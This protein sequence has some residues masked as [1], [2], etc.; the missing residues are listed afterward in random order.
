MI[1]SLLKIILNMFLNLN[2][3]K[4]SYTNNGLFKKKKVNK[5][6]KIKL[7]INNKLKQKKHIINFRY[8]LK[9]F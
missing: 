8:K 3:N 5:K 1:Y 6:D 4:M 7:K 2:H 9:K